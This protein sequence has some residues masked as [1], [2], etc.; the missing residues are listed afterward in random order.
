MRDILVGVSGA[1]GMPLALCLMRLLAWRNCWSSSVAVSLI[2]WGLH[3][4][5]PA[6]QVRHSA[7]N[8]RHRAAPP[9][10]VFRLLSV[11]IF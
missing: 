2:R 1:S 6:G 9:F 4:V 3:T 7:G 5:L 10:A 8:G 11:R